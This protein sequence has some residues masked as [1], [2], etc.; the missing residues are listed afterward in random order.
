MWLPRLREERR[1]VN[2][3]VSVGSHETSTIPRRQPKLLQVTQAPPPELLTTDDIET[4]AT[5]Y[6]G[7]GGR[8]MLVQIEAH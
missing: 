8:E 7:N 6:V 2:E 4:Q 3:V 5:S 1:Q